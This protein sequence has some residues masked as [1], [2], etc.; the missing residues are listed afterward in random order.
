MNW[1]APGTNWNELVSTHNEL[2]STRNELVSTHNELEQHICRIQELDTRLK[3]ILDSRTWR[4]S[5]P[6]RSMEG[7]FR[8]H[9]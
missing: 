9:R 6:L 1:K 5:K 8:R 7:V 4:W 3:R 2:E